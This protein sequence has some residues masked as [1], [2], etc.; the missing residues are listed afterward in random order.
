MLGDLVRQQHVNRSP[1]CIR[2]AV[3]DHAVTWRRD[4]G[5]ADA[6]V[7]GS[8][9]CGRQVSQPVRIGIGIVVDIGDDFASCRVHPEIAR[10]RQSVVFRAYQPDIVPAGDDAGLIG[11][12]VIDHDDFVVRIVEIFQRG[13][14]LADSP[15]AVIAANDYG[16]SRPLT[17]GWRR[18][19]WQIGSKRNAGPAWAGDLVW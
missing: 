7:L 13:Q 12:S 19:R 1:R 18:A 10:N 15:T 14:R 6:D 5:T 9:E 4:I 2:D 17:V 3:G 16:N 8:H 11:R